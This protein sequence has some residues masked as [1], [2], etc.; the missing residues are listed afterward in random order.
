MKTP[1]RL[2]V[3]I[4]AYLSGTCSEEEV[5]DLNSRLRADEGARDLYLRLAQIH[6]RLSTDTDLH[7]AGSSVDKP[8][9]TPI[10]SAAG[11]LV[12]LVARYWLGAAA[13]VV[14]GVSSASVA[15]AIAVSKEPPPI[16]L[17][18]RRFE[19]IT[20]PISPL[21]PLAPGAWSGDDAEVVEL[22]D[23]QLG[24]GRALRFLRAQP[25]FSQPTPYANTCDV[26]QLVDLGAARAQVPQDC[27]AVLT[28]SVSFLDHRTEPGER[29]RF[30]CRMAVFGGDPSRLRKGWPVIQNSQALSIGSDYRWT[31]GGQG[32][33][34]IPLRAKT[35]LPP[36]G[37]FAIIQLLVYR[38]PAQGPGEEPDQ[39]LFGKQYVRDVNLSL[40]FHGLP[41]PQ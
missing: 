23:F 38:D 37:E 39:A 5:E 6:S 11:R 15:W 25:D 40:Q 24:N 10:A 41:R 29:M 20:G 31:E 21:F 7:E 35:V 30:G 16:T 33:E 9:A 8:S 17:P 36:T 28:L 12:S 27:D 26:Y 13:S 34:W 3:L 4:H 14:V 19:E 18:L 22:N 2:A 1:H 32:D